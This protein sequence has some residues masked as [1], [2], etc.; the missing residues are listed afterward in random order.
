MRLGVT[1]D[2]KRPAAMGFTTDAEVIGIEKQFPRGEIEKVLGDAVVNQAVDRPD[3][4]RAVKAPGPSWPGI[5]VKS[6]LENP[7]WEGVNKAF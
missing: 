2:F 3:V 1:I 6:R 5:L 7:E 4:E